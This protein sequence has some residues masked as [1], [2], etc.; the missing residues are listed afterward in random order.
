MYVKNVFTESPC[1]ADGK[2]IRKEPDSA[3]LFESKKQT[4][5][6]LPQAEQQR[7]MQNTGE[8]TT[9]KA[10]VRLRNLHLKHSAISP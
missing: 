1:D 6:T 9:T 2:T 3:S 4:L 7:I 8:L 10:P 5:P